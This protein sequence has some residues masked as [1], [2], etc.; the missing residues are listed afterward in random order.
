MI[1]AAEAEQIAF[2]NY[3]KL[4]GYQIVAKLSTL[5]KRFDNLIKL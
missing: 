1:D 4:Q 5:H 2:D 3:I